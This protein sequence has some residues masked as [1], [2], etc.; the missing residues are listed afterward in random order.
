MEEVV[1]KVNHVK[2][3][4]IIFGANLYCVTVYNSIF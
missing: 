3:F 4:R 1:S 2:Y